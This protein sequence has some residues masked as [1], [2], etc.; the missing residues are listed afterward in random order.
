MQQPQI[1]VGILS[2]KEISFSF[3]DNYVFLNSELESGENYSVRIIDG[4][5]EFQG[6]K[7]PELLFESSEKNATF[8]LHEVTIGVAFH[9]ERKTN[10]TF[11]GRL[12]II[13]SEDRL[14][15]VNIVSAEDYLISVISSEMSASAS[16]E[17]L[18]AHAVISRSWLLAQIEKNKSVKSSENSY[19]SLFC[20]EE[21]YIR[22]YDR[23]DHALFDVC[24][25]D[26]CQR[27]QG[28]SRIISPVS[29]Q[30]VNDTF[31]QVLMF[32]GQICDA[33]FSKCCGGMTEEF[34][35]CWEPEVHPYLKAI[36]DKG[37]TASDEP[38]GDLSNEENASGWIKS[39]PKAF[40]NTS[41]KHILSRI[42]NNYDRETTDF[43]RW[44]VEY[45]QKD[46]SAL[47][48]RRSGFDFGDIIDLIPVE[49]GKSARLV[50]LKIVG[51]KKALIVGK[52]LEIRRILSDSHLYSSA[53]VIEKSDLK[54]DI[55][56][57]FILTGAGWGHGVGLCQIGAA[58][59]GEKGYSY[60]E[61]LKHYFS[62]TTIERRYEF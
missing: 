19:S 7:Y 57:K 48:R 3:N 17:F 32:A 52:E 4:E 38:A 29:L 23:E 53:F 45:T 50:R 62:G 36:S 55:P 18:K 1:S 28:I 35:Y 58:V 43:Y 9:W 60:N 46:L 22:W 44:T 41:D 42:M 14:I 27:Y 59:M 33:R 49:R 20:N 56:Q 47:I 26:H 24:A 40:C 15:A 39:L 21:E 51:S 34:Q 6:G 13:V 8:N 30:A 31:G 12:K 2:E 54:N 16:P 10:Q 61:I 11:P 5:I 25:D 37:T